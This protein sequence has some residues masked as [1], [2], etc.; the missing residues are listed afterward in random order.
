MHKL[1]DKKA[2]IS[3]TSFQA[4]PLETPKPP[5]P[6]AWACPQLP[7]LAYNRVARFKL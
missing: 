6:S 4:L 7:R 3:D 2:F 5:L 1:Q